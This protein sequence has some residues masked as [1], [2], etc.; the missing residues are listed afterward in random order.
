MKP[1]N[2]L[3]VKWAL[4]LLLCLKAIKH[5]TCKKSCCNTSYV[6]ASW[7]VCLVA[8]SGNNQN[9]C[10]CWWFPSLAFSRH[11]KSWTLY[12]CVGIDCGWCVR[13]SSHWQKQDCHHQQDDY[14][15]CSFR[16]QWLWQSLSD[17]CNIIA[18][19]G[20][21]DLVTLKSTVSADIV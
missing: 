10:L 6:Q 15:V 7:V 8:W 2:W 16:Y 18:Q 13:V 11:I 3:S 21:C 19:L 17:G 9:S 14:A 20:W 12:L 4:F 1:L 5:G